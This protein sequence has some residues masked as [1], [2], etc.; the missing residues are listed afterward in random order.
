MI[1]KYPFMAAALSALEKAL[2]AMARAM[3]DKAILAP[4]LNLDRESIENMDSLINALTGRFQK[5]TR[6]GD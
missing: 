5:A 3:G 4:P 6:T 1:E 2:Q